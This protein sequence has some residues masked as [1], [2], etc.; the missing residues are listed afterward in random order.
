MPAGAVL[1][2]ALFGGAVPAGAATYYVSKSGSSDANPCTEAL[3]CKTLYRGLSRLAL[4]DTLVIRAGVYAEGLSNRPTGG[5]ASWAEAVT[6]MAAPGEE[7]VIKP[8][9][10][11]PAYFSGSASQYIVLSGLVLDAGNGGYF[12]TVVFEGG[13]NHIRVTDSEIRAGAA[14]CV[15]LGPSDGG[16]H[17]F[18]RVKVHQCGA[19]GG[20]QSGFNIW[21]SHNIIDNAAVY[22]STGSNIQILGGAGNNIIRFTEVY[23]SVTGY[24]ID[25]NG[26]T[27]NIAHNNIARDN[28]RSGLRIDYSAT[29]AAAIQN[30]VHTNGEYGIYNGSGSTGASLIN[31]ICYGNRLAN[32]KDS[33]TGT[34]KQ[35]NLP[36]P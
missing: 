22:D 36:S 11:N 19:P 3:P 17:E 2:A 31:N 33:G 34:V 8:P 35:A 16:H 30:T 21:S 25:M 26:G 1:A 12:N 6:V 7:V 10:G 4:G 18:V 5:G 27:G 15:K 9:S 24:G 14:G 29:G 13:A 23:S 32:L 20:A 28:A